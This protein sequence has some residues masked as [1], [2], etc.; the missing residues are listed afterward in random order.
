M[1][2]IASAGKTRRPRLLYILT[3]GMFGGLR[4]F[5]LYMRTA[6]FDIYFIASPGPEMKLAGE[7]GISVYE[8]P[9]KREISPFND[10]ISLW[11]IWRLLLR[12][13]PDITNVGTPKAGLLGGLAS[14]FA[15]VRCRIYTLHGLRLETSHGWKRKLLFCAEWLSCRCAHQVYCVSQ[16]L[17]ERA[18]DLNLLNSGKTNVIAKGTF[19]GIEIERYNPTL[20]RKNRASELR[21]EM[22]IDPNQLVIGFVGRMTRDKGLAD[23]YQAYL[24]L[25]SQF[26]NI[27][28]LLIGE[29]ENGDPISKVIRA[30]IDAD[31]NVIRAGWI[32]DPAPYYHVMDVLVMPTYRE[33]FGLASIEAQASEVP[34]VSTKATGA[35]DS[36]I[37]GITGYLTPIGDVPAMAESIARLLRDRNLRLRMG[38]AGRVWVERS[39]NRR[40]VWDQLCE[41]YMNAVHLK[42]ADIKLLML[43]AGKNE[44]L[45]E[46]T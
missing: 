43:E 10:I 36:L 27:R 44:I 18:I 40:F 32:A 28:L 42:Y 17:K 25:R 31:P 2:Q 34:V 30:Q 45:I 22:A 5:V 15:G 33:G 24:L 46:K 29:Y 3:I 16:S 39:F 23:L 20:E 38:E 8:V 6:G 21:K 1:N 19:N 13:R 7:E 35:R 41:K 9:I 26:T 37:D 14:V 12:I 4:E 11:R